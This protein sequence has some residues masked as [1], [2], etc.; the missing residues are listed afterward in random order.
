MSLDNPT[1]LGSIFINLGK[2][3]YRASIQYGSTSGSC[4]QG[5]FHLF[6]DVPLEL[7]SFIPGKR[8]SLK[9]TYPKGKITS[10]PLSQEF[11]A[12]Q[13]GGDPKEYVFNR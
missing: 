11:Y 4:T 3:F 10:V 8:F 6:G 13:E 9:Q 2:G 5:V 7:K 1:W 12:F